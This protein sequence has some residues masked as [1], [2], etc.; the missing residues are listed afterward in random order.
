MG[1][2]HTQE[3]PQ[4]LLLNPLRTSLGRARVGGQ[5]GPPDRKHGLQGSTGSTRTQARNRLLTHQRS[6]PGVLSTDVKGTHRMT[7]TA[8]P[9]W[10]AKQH[11][12]LQDGLVCGGC[13]QPIPRG[14]HYVQDRSR[15]KFHPLCKRAHVTVAKQQY[16]R[17]LVDPAVGATCPGCDHL[18]T[19]EDRIVYRSAIPWHKECRPG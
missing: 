10:R 9:T 2:I 4:T 16:R 7:N 13:K 15:T 8:R 5:A 11:Q 14:T 12:A 1:T 3:P 18:I 6:N 19:D 17:Y